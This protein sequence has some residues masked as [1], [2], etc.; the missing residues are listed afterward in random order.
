M[1]IRIDRATD[2]ALE[3][4]YEIR[5]RVFVDEQGISREEEFDALDPVCIHFLA[6]RDGEPVGTARLHISPNG[7]KAQRVAVLARARRDGVGRDLMLALEAEA[8]KRGLDS[9]AL[10]AQQ[11]AL[12]FYETIGY[13]AE[14]DAFMEADIPHRFMRKHFQARSV[15]RSPATR[16]SRSDPGRPRR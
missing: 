14:G 15:Q 5:R 4:C 11:S 6:R 1:T 2:E 16:G 10:H 12:A 9:V 13:R 3:A 8:K 7:A